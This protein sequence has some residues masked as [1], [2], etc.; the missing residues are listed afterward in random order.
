VQRVSKNHRPPRLGVLLASQAPYAVIFRRGPSKLVRVILWNRERDKFKL[1]Q[2]FRGRI[3]VDRSD[4]SPDGKHLIYFAMGGVAWA[5]P[6]TGGTWTAISRVPSLRTIALWGQGDTWGGG[7][8]FTSNTSY[9]LNLDTNTFLIRD[10]SNLRRDSRRPANSMMQKAGWVLKQ[11]SE[12]GG[13]LEKTLPHGWVLRR[14]TK[15][16]RADRHELER[17]ED[18]TTLAFAAWEWA[19]WDRSR[20]AGLSEDVFALP[21]SGHIS[22]EQFARFTTST[23]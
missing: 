18:S 22:S 1:G 15:F 23:I 12:R 17:A 21:S 6:A 14:I 20:I 11:K 8:M 19:E 3:Y 9:W 5:I 13:I 10:D 7:G 16:G 2:S 4:L